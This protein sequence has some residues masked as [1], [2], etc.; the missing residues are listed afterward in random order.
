MPTVVHKPSALLYALIFLLDIS[1]VVLA[2]GSGLQTLNPA[3][4]TLFYPLIQVCVVC[5]C[6]ALQL[7]SRDM[8]PRASPDLLA[9]VQPHLSFTPRGHPFVVSVN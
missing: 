6:Y 5:T 9:T 4:C 2:I 3:H 8:L 7:Q 1:V